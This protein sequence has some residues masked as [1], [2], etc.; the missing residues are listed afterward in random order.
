MFYIFKVLKL[1]AWEMAFGKKVQTIRD[2]EL[3][4]LN[5]ERSVDRSLALSWIMI[6]FEVLLLL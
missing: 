2:E 5:R 4:Y 1:Y 6:P 3:K